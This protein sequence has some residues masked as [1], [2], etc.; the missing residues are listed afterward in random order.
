MKWTISLILILML[1]AG[2]LLYTNKQLREKYNTSVENVKA[3][4]A[5]L[6]GLKDDNRV[7]KLTVEQ[8]NY[9]NDSIVKKLNE[10]RKELGI[11]DKHIQQLQYELLTA[12]KADT[13]DLKDTIF[14]N[15]FKLDTIVGDKW[16]KT[17][18][19]MKYPST[20]AL[21]PEVTLERHTFINGKRETVNPPKKFFLLRWFQ[22]KHTVVE[23]TTRELNPY[24]EEKIQKYIQIID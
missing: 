20:I 12:S 2:Y 10:S 11:K 17:H 5:Q 16:V 7:F 14:V 9:F 13:L 6:G 19:H 24:V 1:G 15:N 21:K 23:V 22:K 3:Y 18:L 4:D 8:L